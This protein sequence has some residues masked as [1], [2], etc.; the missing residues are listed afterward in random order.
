M[1]LCTCAQGH[2]LGSR[3]MFQ[4]EILTINVIPGIVY[5]REIIYERSRNVNE[6]PPGAKFTNM[7]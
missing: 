4:L 7:D 2:A 3:K 1:K 5:V 6:Q